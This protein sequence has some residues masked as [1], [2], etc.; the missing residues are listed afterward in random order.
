MAVVQ[1][2]PYKPKRDTSMRAAERRWR[3]IRESLLGCREVGLLHKQ[4]QDCRPAQQNTSITV[5]YCRTQAGCC[6]MW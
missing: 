6:D 5:H 2:A 3:P 1:I 4:M